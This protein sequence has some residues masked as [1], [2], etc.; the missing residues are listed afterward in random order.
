[1][2]SACI[3]TRDD[4]A[5]LRACLESI[6]PHV[7]ELILVDTGSIDDSPRIAR[8]YADRFA[9]YLGCNDPATEQIQ[10]FADAR[11]YAMSLA[12]GDVHVW[13]DAD[14]LLVGGENI[15][16]LCD[17]M[18]PEFLGLVPYEYQHDAAGR[19]VC[20]H[21]RENIVKPRDKWKWS[22]PVHEVMLP[23][24]IAPVATPVHNIRRIHRKQLST[25]APDPERNLRI[26]KRYVAQVGEGDVRAWYYLGVEYSMR[27]DTSN[28]LRV[29]KRYIELAGW[30]DEKCL[31]LLEVARIY[32]RMGDWSLSID[33]AMRAMVTK[34]W[35]EPYF[36][37]CE[38]FAALCDQ[39]VD[40]ATNMRRAAHFGELGLSM[41]DGETVLFV[42]PMKRF[43]ALSILARIYVTM[44]QIEQALAAT[45]QYLATIPE[46]VEMQRL[47]LQCEDVL[48]KNTLVREA[49]R[50]A[51]ITAKL[52]ELGAFDPGQWAQVHQLVGGVLGMP[53]PT[54]AMLA[55]VH[56]APQPKGDGCLDVV[57][58]LGQ[59]YEPWNPV[60]LQSGGM[61]GSETMAW[62]LARRLRAIGHRVRVFAH[63]NADQEGVFDGVEWLNFDKYQGVECDTLVSSRRADSADGDV[64][65]GARLLWVHDVH[66]G[67]ALT[68]ARSLRWDRILC[69]SEWHKAF[70]LQCY[71][72][73]APALIAALRPE[74]IEV[75]RNGIDLA[76]FA[77][78]ETLALGD[79]RG[80]ILSISQHPPEW[81]GGQIPRWE[82]PGS[83][84]V[85]GGSVT[86]A[87]DWSSLVALGV[88]HCISITNPP[89]IGVPADRMLHDPTD[90][91]GT[92][93]KPEH[94]ARIVAFARKALSEGGK[95]YLHCWV[96]ASRS[97]S[98]A[99]A[100]L[101]AVYGLGKEAAFAAIGT[102]Y[103]WGSPYG[104]DPKHVAY[105]NSIDACVQPSERNPKRV[106]Y[107]SSPDRGLQTLLE[108]WPAILKQEPE[109][110]LHVFYGFDGWEKSAPQYGDTPYLGVTS[111]RQV[112][113]MI[114]SLPSV[115]A[116][117]RVSGAQLAG[118]MLVSGVMAYPSWFSETSGISFMEAQ[119]AGLYLVATPIA[120]LNETIGAS[121]TL[122][123]G[124]WQSPDGPTDD[125]RAAFVQAVV[126][127][128]RGEQQP[129]TREELQS[130]AARFDLDTLAKDWDAMLRRI[131]SET[132][133]SV[134]PGWVA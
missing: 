92:P 19:P 2:I 72:A 128:M 122:I 25:R 68:P 44:G 127:A 62:E 45:K 48:A 54:A 130:E 60:T 57:F 86:G 31:A 51:G 24:G 22:I 55:P 106:I 125:D 23:Q 80:G 34:S 91:D 65:A 114:R 38:C 39:G 6:R 94:I 129:K 97:P 52:R 119:A 35:P 47:S 18:G 83:R 103:P 5:T 89:D 108:M 95:L 33:W 17:A 124:A 50:S 133:E 26:L 87:A 41:K 69:L 116:H 16:P 21:Y 9:T 37:I 27:N 77:R 118:E 78:G 131:L 46:D 117:G 112:K 84:V 59:A 53:Q 15:R 29:L 20:I 42:N 4:G 134:L 74:Q 67:E 8:E 105:M 28:A 82:I 113:H 14:D 79:S 43:D 85:I 64:R 121:G 58:Y 99:Y 7:D 66:V 36:L 73:G 96:G 56:V 13:I 111:M 81:G 61:G 123:P 109:A 126:N 49:Q 70:M 75:T 110:E 132:E 100:V 115:T 107:S 90:D 63:C 88:T 104:S 40:P 11:N 1:M 120:A 32:Q 12:T 101:R 93:F 76:R 30:H 71:A 98:F 102:H 3:L 10:D